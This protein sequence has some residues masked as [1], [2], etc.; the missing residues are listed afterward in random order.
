MGKTIT[1]QVKPSDT[2]DSAKAKLQDKECIPPDQ[3]DLMFAYK[4]LEERNTL[5]DYT[6][7][8]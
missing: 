2:T 1:L 5:S 8:K 3:Q 4:H 6:I 7:Q